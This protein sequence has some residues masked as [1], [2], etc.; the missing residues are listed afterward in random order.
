MSLYGS[1]LNHECVHTQIIFIFKW[2]DFT[3]FLYDDMNYDGTDTVLQLLK[4]VFYFLGLCYAW[5]C[6]NKD[7]Q[8][9]EP[10][11]LSAMWSRGNRNWG[12]V[13]LVMCWPSKHN[14]LNLIATP[15][16]VFKRPDVGAQVCNPNTGQ[17]DK[18]RFPRLLSLPASRN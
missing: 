7:K 9:I 2:W 12:I 16:T 5:Q 8:N 1:V 3:C 6:P 4:F 18:D 11:L 17:G 10:Q 13:H 15:P 14:D